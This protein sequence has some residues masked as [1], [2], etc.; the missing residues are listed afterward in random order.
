M[1]WIT[2]WKQIFDMSYH[3]IS[4]K[5]FSGLPNLVWLTFP[6]IH[7]VKSLRDPY[8]YLYNL[9]WLD[10][11]YNHIQQ[12][13][14]FTLKETKCRIL[15]TRSILS[16]NIM[17]CI[18]M[19]IQIHLKLEEIWHM[20]V[21]FFTLLSPVYHTLLTCWRHRVERVKW[22]RRGTHTKLLSFSLMFSDWSEFSSFS[23]R[24]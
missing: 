14:Q 19:L 8:H 13:Y 24:L 3:K 18:K 10:L 12:V 1:I 6:W 9:A 2:R 4:Y 21:E 17:Y 5:V 7:W 22:L 15:S 11:G 20:I 16:F 23:Q